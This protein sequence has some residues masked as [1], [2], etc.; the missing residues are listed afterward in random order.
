MFAALSVASVAAAGTL[1]LLNSAYGIGDVA[2]PAPQA[3]LMK[4][5]VEGIMTAQLPWTLV[6]IGVA[7]AVFCF[8]AK[9]PILAVALVFTFP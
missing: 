2:V 6:F 7:L 4:M 8:M 9:I 1:I 5:I 3:T